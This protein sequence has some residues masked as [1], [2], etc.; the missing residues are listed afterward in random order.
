MELQKKRESIIEAAIRLFVEKGFDAASMQE[1]AVLAGVAK[2]TIY[3]YFSSKDELVRQVY[4]H[5]FQMDRKACNVGLNHETSAADKLC[6]RLDNIMNFALEHPLEAQIEQLYCLSP[7]YG[8][9]SH[10]VQEALYA[11]IEEI[12]RQGIASGELKE[13]PSYLLSHIYYGIMATLYLTF[14]QKK[15]DWLDG[16]I[17]RQ[18][19]QIVRDSMLRKEPQQESREKPENGEI[20]E[21]PENPD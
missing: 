6:R 1:I 14:M 4:E 5:C 19:R 12:V 8:G 15:E 3:L 21:I 9:R 16:K 10:I 20:P 18:C 13:M 2:G 11:D 7:V 17:R